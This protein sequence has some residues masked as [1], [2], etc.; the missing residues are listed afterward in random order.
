MFLATLQ[1]VTKSQNSFMNLKYLKH[2]FLVLSK[3]HTSK[4]TV[5][6]LAWWLG[7]L[8]FLALVVLFIHGDYH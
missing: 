8:T 1:K 7:L 6:V 4:L 3:F 5:N 2:Y